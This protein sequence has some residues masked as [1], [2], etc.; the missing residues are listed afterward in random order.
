MNESTFL[1]TVITLYIGYLVSSVIS[2]LFVGAFIQSA[3]KIK[4]IKISDKGEMIIDGTTEEAL[5]A[6]VVTKIGKLGLIA[7][8]LLM[9]FAVIIL[10]ED[11]LLKDIIALFSFLTIV[12][13]SFIVCLAMMDRLFFRS[14]CD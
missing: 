14:L 13:S 5:M 1:S 2:K 10:G 4:R 9:A 8:S 11:F 6:L 12:M 7:S 3:L